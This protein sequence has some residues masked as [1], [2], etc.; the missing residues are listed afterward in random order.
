MVWDISFKCFD[1]A[2]KPHLMSKKAEVS[3][4]A[5]EVKVSEAPI[6]LRLAMKRCLFKMDHHP[7][8]V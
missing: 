6:E 5:S 2:L 7:M 3:R 4:V 1:Q 8:E